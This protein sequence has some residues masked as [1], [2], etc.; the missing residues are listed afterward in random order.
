M[1]DP[2]ASVQRGRTDIVVLSKGLPLPAFEVGVTAFVG[3]LRGGGQALVA[4][5]CPGVVLVGDGGEV[6]LG[7]WGLRLG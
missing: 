2:A 7:A 3:E 6:A 4:R 5:C 1:R